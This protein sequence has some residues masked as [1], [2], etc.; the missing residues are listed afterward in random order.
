MDEKRAVELTN[1]WLA[2]FE[3][4]LASRD[5]ERLSATFELECHWRDLVAFT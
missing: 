3:S 2:E 5:A 1:R 4:A